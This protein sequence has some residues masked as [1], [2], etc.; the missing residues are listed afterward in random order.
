M[1][2]AVLAMSAGVVVITFIAG[3]I[4]TT[5]WLPQLNP[6]IIGACFLGNLVLMSSIIVHPTA[7]VDNPVQSYIVYF[8]LL[9]LVS[10]GLGVLV[11]K[12]IKKRQDDKY[13]EYEG[14]G[15][16]GPPGSNIDD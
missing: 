14:F 15:D 8:G 6:Q 3:L 11:G 7:K 10:G 12:I 16:F 1:D 4:Y 5:K 13:G 9:V 2:P